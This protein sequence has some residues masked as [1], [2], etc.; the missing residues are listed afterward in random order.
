MASLDITSCSCFFT[1]VEKTFS[2]DMFHRLMGNMNRFSLGIG[3][4]I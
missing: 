4:F 2:V 3:N 1:T